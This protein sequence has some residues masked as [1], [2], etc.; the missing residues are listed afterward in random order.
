MKIKEEYKLDIDEFNR[1]Y[2][3]LEKV[4][5]L[6]LDKY[7]QNDSLT[8]EQKASIIASSIK[9]IIEKSIEATFKSMLLE[10]E[11]L[12]AQGNL[13]KIKEDIARAKTETL[14]LPHTLKYENLQAS[15]KY[16]NSTI[17]DYA[18]G[19]LVIP[20]DMMTKSL[21]LV[22]TLSKTEVVIG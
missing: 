14:L 11:I 7:I 19:G 22:D 18:L 17:G 10:D 13:A 16:L 3:E 15:L 5:T 8:E 9:T 21:E 4:T 6:T 20:T 1:I 12:L 2:T